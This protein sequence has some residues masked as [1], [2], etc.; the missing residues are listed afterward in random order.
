MLLVWTKENSKLD[1]QEGELLSF[2]SYPLPLLLLSL[3]ADKPP[4]VSFCSYSSVSSSHRLPKFS[5]L[6][7]YEWA[8]GHFWRDSIQ[9]CCPIRAWSIFSSLSGIQPGGGRRLHLAKHVQKE[10]E[11][12]EGE[13]KKKKKEKRYFSVLPK[14]NQSTAGTVYR[15]SV[16]RHSHLTRGL[17]SCIWHQLPRLDKQCLVGIL[18]HLMQLRAALQREV[19]SSQLAE[20]RV[21]MQIINHYYEINNAIFT[22]KRQPKDYGMPSSHSA[23]VQLSLG[24]F[25]LYTPRAAGGCAA[26]LYSSEERKE[27][28]CRRIRVR[29]G[30]MTKMSL[31]RVAVCFVVVVRASCS[32]PVGTAHLGMAATVFPSCPSSPPQLWL[33]RWWSSCWHHI[34]PHLLLALYVSV[35]N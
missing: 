1:L 34:K 6:L 5:S 17:A 29:E 27:G 24:F 33:S 35:C 16:Q 23:L 9:L 7:T 15:R 10:L 14:Q 8:S 32:S 28:L 4:P 26:S 3:T 18:N 11:Q 12:N 30:L 20:T 31:N 25:T 2:A 22:S 21:A 13:G 19:C